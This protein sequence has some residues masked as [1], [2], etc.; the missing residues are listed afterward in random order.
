MPSATLTSK[1]QIT[2]P[3]PVREA[4]GVR[5]GDR[6]DFVVQPDGQ[7]IARAARTDVSELRGVLYRPGRRAV[8]LAQMEA[9]IERRGARR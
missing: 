4:L 7:V 5:T 3:K 8:T 6:V 1:G 9:A 2:L